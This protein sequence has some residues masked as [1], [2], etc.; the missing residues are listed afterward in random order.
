MLAAARRAGD[1]RSEIRAIAY[2]I[3]GFLQAADVAAA[4]RALADYAALAEKL[5][6]PRHLWHVPIIRATRALMDGRFAEARSSREEGAAARSDRRGAALGSSSTRS[7]WESCAP[8]RATPRRCCPLVRRMVEEYPAIPAWR[9][10]LISFLA[11]ADRLEEARVE[12]EPI[13][14][15][16]FDALPL[17]ANWLVGITPDRRGRGSAWRSRCLQR[18]ARRGWRP[19]RARS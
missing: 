3:T 15:R 6:E 17:D 13:V 8:S 5:G 18:A 16:G 10:A 12:Y 11:E 1:R 19:S 9:L 2:L 14:A 4:D 7:R